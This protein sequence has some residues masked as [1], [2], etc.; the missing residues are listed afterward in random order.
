[1]EWRGQQEAEQLTLQHGDRRAHTNIGREP[2]HLHH[3][4]RGARRAPGSLLTSA[5]VKKHIYPQ[6]SSEAQAIQI[7]TER[8]QRSETFVNTI[9]Q[10]D[11]R[12][13]TEAVVEGVKVGIFVTIIVTVLGPEVCCN[14]ALIE[15]LFL[16][17]RMGRKLPYKLQSRRPSP[18]FYSFFWAVID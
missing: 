18:H 3:Q 7:S 9:F 2:P 5:A 1:M 13:F 17:R 6:C 4:T 15:H 8:D 12:S 16:Q 11:P 14:E 10:V